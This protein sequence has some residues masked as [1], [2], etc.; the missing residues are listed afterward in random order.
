HTRFSRD[1]SSDVCSSDLVT[2][3]GGVEPLLHL[4]KKGGIVLSLLIHVSVSP[5]RRQL[6]PRP[7]RP[8]HEPHSL[9]RPAWP[10]RTRLIPPL[11]YPSADSPLGRKKGLFPIGGSPCPPRASS[12]PERPRWLRHAQGLRQIGRATSRKS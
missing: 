8:A 7:L 2:E 4:R 10:A 12:R 11:I 9:P 6:W 3:D 1:W 5:I